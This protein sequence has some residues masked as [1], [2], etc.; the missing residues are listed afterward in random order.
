M[1]KPPLNK[2]HFLITH[3]IHNIKLI[4]TPTPINAR[5]TLTNLDKE[6]SILSLQGDTAVNKPYE[7]NMDI[8]SNTQLDIAKI[9]DT[10]GFFVLKHGD[11]YNV[12]RT[13]YGKVLK[14]K[15]SSSISSKFIYNITL[16]SPLYYLSLNKRFQIYQGKNVPQLIQEILNKY[17]S[18]L[19]IKVDIQIDNNNY[20]IREYITQYEQSDLEFITMIATQEAIA[21]NFDNSNEK[22][23]IV[24]LIDLNNNSIQVEDEIYSSWNK[25]KEFT[26]SHANKLFYDN[27]NPSLKNETNN[28]SST[29]TQSIKDNSFTSQLR[30]AL[31]IQE[32]HDTLDM[33]KG[34]YAKNLQR[35]TKLE[36][37]KGYSNSE[38]IQGSTYNI[39]TNDCTK[40]T[41][42]DE[43]NNRTQKVIIYQ[44]SM[45]AYFPNA[46]EQ[47]INNTDEYSFEVFF[48]A[49]PQD[50]IYIPPL[51]IKQPTIKGIQT[52]IVSKGNSKTKDDENDVDI[53]NQG[54]I[55]VIFHFDINYPTS[56]YIRASNIT[57]GN[58][59]GSQFI[60]R[61]NT[62]V[63]VSFI[64]GNPNYPVIIGSLYNGDN[65]IPYDAPSNKTKSYIKTA[66]M[67]QH[68]DTEGYNELLFDD[69]QSNELL[70]L[71]A[72]KNYKLH[73][74]NN[75]QTIIDNDKTIQV[76]NDYTTNIQGENNISVSKNQ[77]QQISQNQT[78]TVLKNQTTSISGNK[79][80]NTTGNETITTS[81]TK[82]DNIKLAS[83]QLVG[84]AKALNIGGAY[85]IGVGGLKHETIGGNSTEQVGDVKIIQANE[86]LK[87]VVGKSSMIIRKDGKIDLY[88]TKLIIKGQDAIQINAN[89]VVLNDES[90][91]TGVEEELQPIL[92]GVSSD[93]FSV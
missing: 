20:P 82:H 79:T 26:P 65:K 12:Q 3:N 63:I 91:A 61:V 93:S 52:A 28:V 43:A 62:E 44:T 18:L 86:E 81:G 49:V 36:S 67:P 13:V 2:R 23:S 4:K 24:S 17:S 58:N 64:N 75:S 38:I 71:R 30:D 48:K 80:T 59:Y 51:T 27:T 47:L 32:V 9:T 73:A 29:D 19:N 85:Q 54:R 10:D 50:T 89:N 37:T 41:L 34:S 60:P 55:K 88:G 33:H 70:S 84:G 5:L 25:S 92:R 68:K 76:G 53:D 21:L 15:E 69:K 8:V 1:S 83:T 66:S 72:Q 11:D 35:Y 6:F 74:L 16:V 7:F 77:T 42:K 56:C 46:L 31:Q 57:S 40:A 87:I 22:N 45:K 78:T 90:P 39:F 14:A